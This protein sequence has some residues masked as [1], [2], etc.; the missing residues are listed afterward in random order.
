MRIITVLRQWC[1]SNKHFSKLAPHHGGKTAGID[2]VW[3]NCVTVTLCITLCHIGMKT[4]ELW[5][6]AMMVWVYLEK[7]FKDHASLSKMAGKHKEYA[8]C[9]Y[10]RLNASW[11]S[12]DSLVF[13]LWLNNYYGSPY[14]VMHRPLCFA[15]VVSSSSSFFLSFFLS[16]F[17]LAWSQRLQIGC[18]PHFRHDVALVQI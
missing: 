18:L 11:L 16:L 12:L 1:H 15:A 7:F 5:M 2:M 14:I 8:V 10:S 9:L 6:V 3:R 17:F 13:K 4:I